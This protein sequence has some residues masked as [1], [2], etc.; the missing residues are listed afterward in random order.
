MRGSNDKYLISDWCV[1]QIQPTM[2]VWIHHRTSPKRERCKFEQFSGFSQIPYLQIPFRSEGFLF[3]LSLTDFQNSILQEKTLPLDF[4]K[5]TQP[6]RELFDEKNPFKGWI[7]HDVF[8]GRW[9]YVFFRSQVTVSI[10]NDCTRFPE[11]QEFQ[12][13]IQCTELDH[14]RL[15]EAEMQVLEA[16]IW[17]I[18]VEKSPENSRNN[19]KWLGRCIFLLKWSLFRGH[20]N[21]LPFFVDLLSP[22]C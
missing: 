15:V 6:L 19:I 18:L 12:D 16:K 5:T 8:L 3:H 13:H 20:M 22:L 10:C 9:G 2:F 11:L 1:S 17:P 14:L 7:F 4:E 21:S